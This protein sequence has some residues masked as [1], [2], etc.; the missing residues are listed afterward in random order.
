MRQRRI[1]LVQAL[2]LAVL[3]LG[4]AQAN[5]LCTFGGSGEATLQGSF[6]SLLGGN[7]L[8]A[9]SDCVAD[10]ADAAWSTVGSIGQL[11]IMLE[12]AGNAA[13]NLFGV[14][15]LNDP[16]Q[17]LAIFDGADAAGD[18]AILRLRETVNG[19]R[20]SVLGAGASSWT[21]QVISTS[22]FGFF[23]SAQGQGTFFSQTAR[24]A[25]GVDHLYAYQ[26]T[27][28]PFI[29][30]PLSGEVFTPHDYILAWEDLAGGGDRDYQ[31]FV[32]VVQ[33]I[34]PVPL[35]TPVLLLISGLVGLAGV[36]RRNA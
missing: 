21:H 30:G 26:G 14:Y 19:W 12:L 29:S 34:A 1:T 24:N 6:D 13:T 17:R 23:L 10:G 22:A 7:A 15:D 9:S 31:D 2:S 28:T 32:A 11:D 35:P 36:S 16:T 25:D 3:S 4:A 20:V 27:S 8:H 33:D 18:Q 5:A